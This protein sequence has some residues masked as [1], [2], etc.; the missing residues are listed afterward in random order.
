[1]TTTE[2]PCSA[3]TTTSGGMVLTCSRAA[4]HDGK[5]TATNRSI[6]LLWDDPAPQYRGSSPFADRSATGPRPL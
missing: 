4:E 6:T 5:H 2:S 3:R 1:M